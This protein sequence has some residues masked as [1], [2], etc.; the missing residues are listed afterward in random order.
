[1]AKLTTLKNMTQL[2]SQ[3][4]YLPE[5]IDR[6][7]DKKNPSFIDFDPELGYVLR[8]YSFN[9]GDGGIRC[10]YRYEK[11]GGHRTMINYADRPCRINTYGDSY[12]QCAQ[13]SGGQSWQELLAAQFHEPIRNFGVG[14]YGVYQAYRRLMRTEAD[15]K[16]AAEFLVLNMWDDDHKRNLDAARWVRVAWMCRD[17]PRGGKNAYPVHGFPWAHMRYDLEKGTFIELPGMC[18]KASDLRKLV[19][20]ENFINAF[21]NDHVAQLYCLGQGGSAP[22]NQLEPI[23]EALGVKVDL[24]NPRTRQA[25]ADKL[26]LAYGMRASMW[27]VDQLKVW[28]KKQKRKLMI[29]LSYDVPTVKTYLKTGARWDQPMLNYLNKS[30]VPYVDA[31]KAAGTEYKAFKLPIDQFLARHYV[32]RAGAQV[33]GHYNAYGNFWYASAVRQPI[34]DW[35]SPKPPAYR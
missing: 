18:K 23:A 3:G 29:Q 21:K 34:V 13:V 9:D 22:V 1:M 6:I 35:L 12:T 5:E 24:R 26:H 33:F 28:A 11:H 19:G 14:G 30:G 4:A 15:P 16:L 8:D 20:K 31:L 10:D 7:L 17:L 25:E 27:I 32:S 2:L